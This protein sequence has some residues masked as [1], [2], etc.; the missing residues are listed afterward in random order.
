MI[1]TS[2]AKANQQTANSTKQNDS[3]TGQQ[4]SKTQRVKA[5]GEILHRFVLVVRKNRIARCE[6]VPGTSHRK[7]RERTFR[8]KRNE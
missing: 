1:K 4:R 5:D 7:T 6:M 2:V 3:V 8:S